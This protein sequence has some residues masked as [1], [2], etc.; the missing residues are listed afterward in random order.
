MAA[1]VLVVGGGIAALEAAAA[2]PALAGSRV[3]TTLVA[4]A[5]HFEPRALSVNAP[6]GGRPLSISLPELARRIPRGIALGLGVGAE[7]QKPLALVVIGGLSLSTLVTLFAVPTFY[8]ALRRRADDRRNE[9][10]PPTIP[11]PATP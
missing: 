5:T 9:T 2:L 6:F 8:A 3:R 1:G 4:P 10:P 7:L 11:A